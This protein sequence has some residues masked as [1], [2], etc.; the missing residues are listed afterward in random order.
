[1]SSSP[2]PVIQARELTKRYPCRL[3]LARRLAYCCALPLKPRPDDFTALQDV[4]FDVGRG[5]VVGIVGPNGSGKSTLLQIVA[6]LL[7]PTEGH[8]RVRGLTAAL[9]ELGAGFN[10]EFSGRENIFLS[11][12]V[13][14]LGR[15]QMLERYDAIVAFADIGPHL[16]QPVK[17]YSSG[18]FARLAFAVA[19]EVNPDII[20]VDEILSVG[21]VAFQAKCFRRIE[22]LR[23]AGTS[24]LFVSHDMNAVQ[25]LCDRAILLNRGREVTRGNPK[26]VADTYLSVMN[27]AVAG[28]APGAAPAGAAAGYQ[29]EIHDC[30]LLNADG[31]VTRNPRPGEACVFEYRV[32]FNDAVAEPVV[33]FQVRS[34]LGLV[35]FDVTNRFVKQRLPPCGAGDELTVR[36]ALALNLCPGP[37]RIGVGVAE[38]GGDMPRALYGIDD[39]TIEVV[40]N[41]P[42]YGVVHMNAGMTV[43]H[44]PAHGAG[45][46]PTQSQ[47]GTDGS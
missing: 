8:V 27:Q 20:L 14:G 6:G 34:L 2:E 25:T 17:T 26:D 9:L 39:L 18:M 45:Q 11:G 10:P 31:E 28:A 37:Y 30:R 32:R 21:D 13:Y 19:I 12:A 5:E 1:M 47:G 3:P 38:G 41:R 42:E 16:D 15:R 24:I 29:A 23:D 22:Q 7:E 40:S 33:T 44:E 46:A 36:I 4:S 43:E 35:L